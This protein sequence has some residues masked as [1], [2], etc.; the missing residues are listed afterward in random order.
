MNAAEMRMLRWICGNTRRERIGNKNIC[1]MVGITLIENQLRENKLK[2][3]GHLQ[4]LS[5]NAAI[6]KSDKINELK[7]ELIKVR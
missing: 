7:L 1:E 3:F 6:D 4:R 5:V 2:W